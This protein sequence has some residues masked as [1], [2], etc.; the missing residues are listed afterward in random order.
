MRLK[1]MNRLVVMFMHKELKYVCFGLLHNGI[2]Q[3]AKSSM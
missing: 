3:R 1:V 2:S